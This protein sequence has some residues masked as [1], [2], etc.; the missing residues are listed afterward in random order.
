MGEMIKLDV[1]EVD[2]VFYHNQSEEAATKG[3]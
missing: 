2:G 3:K 1:D